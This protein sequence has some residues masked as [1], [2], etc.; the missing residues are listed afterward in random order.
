MNINVLKTAIQILLNGNK[1][2]KTTLLLNIR[3]WFRNTDILNKMYI[4]NNGSNLF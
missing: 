4:M 2:K 3:M 1:N